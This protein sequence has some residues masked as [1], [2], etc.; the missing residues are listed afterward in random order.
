MVDLL[1]VLFHTRP[2]PPPPS[3]K[4]PTCDI[5]IWTFVR[6]HD[7]PI[8]LVSPWLLNVVFVQLYLLLVNPKTAHVTLSLFVKAPFTF[9]LIK[10]LQREYTVVHWCNLLKGRK[11]L[12]SCCWMSPARPP[13]SEGTEGL[14]FSFTLWLFPTFAQY[15]PFPFFVKKK[16]SPH[17][18]APFHTAAWVTDVSSFCVFP[19]ILRAEMS[20]SIGFLMVFKLSIIQALK[21]VIR[22]TVFQ[23]CKDRL[24][25]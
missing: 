6:S 24:N 19:K 5:W 7:F 9:I 11:T 22:K 12:Y 8:I 10:C 4:T 23:K 16:K 13:A 1:I 18:N 17:Y 25:H 14:F 2:V 3:P 21:D 20:R 15:S